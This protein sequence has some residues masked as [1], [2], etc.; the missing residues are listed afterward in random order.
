MEGRENALG[1]KQTLHVS[2]GIHPLV[3]HPNDRDSVFGDAKVN[4]MP[5]DIAAAVPQTNMAARWSLRLNALASKRFGLPLFSPSINAART[6]SIPAPR[7][8][9]AE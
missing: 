3:K 1:Y 5:L 9:L 7:L 8:G 4:H 2:R 6:T